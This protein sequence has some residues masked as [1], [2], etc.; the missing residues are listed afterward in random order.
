MISELEQAKTLLKHIL[1][2]DINK[3]NLELCIASGGPRDK[4][5]EFRAVYQSEDLMQTFREA[6]T[7]ILKPYREDLDDDTLRLEAFLADTVK[8]DHV[9]EYLNMMPYDS[10]KQQMQPVEQPLDRQRFRHDEKD[11][12]DKM[13]FYVIR[14]E[15]PG[16]PAINFYH[17]YSPAQMLSRS[18]VFAMVLEQDRYER[19]KQ[20]TFLFERLIDCFSCEEHMFILQ[21]NNFFQI[22]PLGELEKVAHETLDILEKK[23]Y[24]HNFKRFR[25][26]CLKD[27]RKILKLKNIS[28]NGYLDTL[29]IDALHENVRRY[30]ASSITVDIVNGKKK[31]VYDPRHCWEFLYILN[32]DYADSHMTGNSYRVSGKRSVSR[33]RK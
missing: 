5:Y 23:E 20:P 26:D 7:E 32:D 24:I 11:F 29:T 8:E 4:E 21:K 17:R 22:F 16:E 12:I 31:L 2:L 18:S 14:V 27:K 1:T 28:A 9:V 10:F 33:A 13:R 6:L 3:C 30:S 15:P 19:L 25:D